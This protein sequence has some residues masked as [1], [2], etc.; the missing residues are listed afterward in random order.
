MR[1]FAFPIVV[2][3]LVVVVAGCE[4][5]GP[6]EPTPAARAGA[7]LQ[8]RSDT[9][10]PVRSQDAATESTSGGIMIGSGTK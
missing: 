1:R 5:S 3:A 10:P 7:I 6:T 8:V 2:V 9:T 4:T